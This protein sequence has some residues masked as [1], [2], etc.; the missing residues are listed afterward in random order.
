MVAEM[1]ILWGG[2]YSS[3]GTDDGMRAGV[4][5]LGSGW[6]PAPEGQVDFLQLQTGTGRIGVGADHAYQAGMIR[7]R[8]L[9]AHLESDFVAGPAGKPVG[10][11]Q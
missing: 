3:L 9:A 7:L 6:K 10:V 5:G 2:P 1:V 4:K 11:T 8:C